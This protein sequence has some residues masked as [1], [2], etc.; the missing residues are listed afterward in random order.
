MIKSVLKFIDHLFGFNSA[1]YSH[2]FTS[3]SHVKSAAIGDCLLVC[4]TVCLS[5]SVIAAA[6]YFF[7][8][9]LFSCFQSQFYL[10]FVAVTLLVG[11]C[12]NRLRN[13]LF[14]C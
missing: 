10:D 1:R 13:D 11:L 14:F 7:F 2:L 3:R 8:T 12:E 6:F 5:V 9:F 4:L